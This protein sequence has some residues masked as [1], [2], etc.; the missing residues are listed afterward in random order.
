MKRKIVEIDE[1]TCNGCGLCVPNCAEGAIKIIDGKARLVKDIYC[2]GLGACLG[3]CP[4]DAIRVIEREAEAFDEKAVQEYLGTSSHSP[5]KDVHQ[6]GPKAQ[7]IAHAGCPG[8]ALRQFAQATPCPT[9]SPFPSPFPSPSN[10]VPAESQL[11]H[12][13]VQLM[14]VP[15][16]APYLRD[17]DLVI[18][19]DCVPF[20]VP[21]FHQRYLKGRAV[22]VG[23]PKLD[24]VDYYTEKL[25]DVFQ[26][27]KPRKITVLRMEVPCCGG[28]S[29]A[30]M[31]A[32]QKA[33]N[34]IPCEVHIVGIQGG[35][36]I[37]AVP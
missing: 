32:R 20:A 27:A 33:G 34:S 26:N 16:S 2:D 8:S 11:G 22:L 36:T 6:P 17:A 37:Q 10:S 5:S 28:M 35:I 7:G 9:P 12:W 29:H 19:A 3:H 30:V 21:D 24:D 14:L 18:C 25:S 15:A 13:P 23:C 4:V 31:Q 1:E